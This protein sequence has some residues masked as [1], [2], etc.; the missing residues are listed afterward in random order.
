MQQR[1]AEK[2]KA[3]KEENLRILA[4]KARED[5]ARGGRRRHS[6]SG[7]H[8]NSD[9][10]SDSEESDDDLA[11]R[12]REEA[13][14]EKY[15][16][17]ERKLRQSRMGAERRIQVLAREQNRDISEKIALGLAK[18]SQSKETM[19]DSRLFNQSSGFDSGFNEDNPY[20]KPLFAAQDA[21][22]SIYRPRAN[23][24]DDDEATGE[25]EMD[26]IH[27]SSRFGE[28][29]GRG[30]FKGAETVEVSFVIF[31]TREDY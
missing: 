13:R 31:S 19:Y 8:S 20:D 30:K 6:R 29:L 16:E 14:R 9:A 1:L 4:A 22:N 27:K 12:E 15:R 23:A 11:I 10:Y 18:P 24:E 5:A 26:K 28:V 21:I 2:E 3:Q 7:S 25:R 17:E